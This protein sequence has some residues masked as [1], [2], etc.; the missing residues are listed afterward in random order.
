[1]LVL[2]L[3]A[4]KAHAWIVPEARGESTAGYALGGEQ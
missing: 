4:V 1:M 3:S 2:H